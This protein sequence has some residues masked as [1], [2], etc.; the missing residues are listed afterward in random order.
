VAK[1]FSKLCPILASDIYIRDAFV[2][3]L[4]AVP[5]QRGLNI[6]SLTAHSQ[7]SLVIAPR[8]YTIWRFN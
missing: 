3:T 1:E 6:E 4:F 5:N 8:K 7:N 2:L